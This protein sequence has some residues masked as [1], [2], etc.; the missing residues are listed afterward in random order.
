[1]SELDVL[2]LSE[3]ARELGCHVETLRERVRDGRLAAHRGPHGVYLVTRAALRT[4]LAPR[5]GRPRQD[6]YWPRLTSKLERRSWLEVE[7]ILFDQSD[8]IDIERRL[9][10]ALRQD[11][12]FWPELYNLVS[13]HRLAAVGGAVSWIAWH[14]D[15]SER[16]VRRL[17]QKRLWR[18]LRYL[19]AIRWTRLN[20]ALA[21]RR[22]GELIEILRDRLQAERVPQSAVRWKR[23]KLNIYEQQALR[24]AGVT[25]EELTSIWM[26]GLTH[27]EV[28]HLLLKGT[29]RVATHRVALRT[30]FDPLD[31]LG[32]RRPSFVEPR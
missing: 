8:N 31:P 12:E 28:N 3:A 17:A 32:H 26:E 29:P 5:R 13:V 25:D 19:L 14:L 22:A 20:G 9:L 24:S 11:P 18:T 23:H 2:R 7:R 30:K 27:I 15:I 21:R 16:H 6:L 4:Q 10:R 1:M